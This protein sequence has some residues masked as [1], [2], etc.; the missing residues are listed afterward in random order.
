M[1]PKPTPAER[2]AFDRTTFDELNARRQVISLEISR[3]LIRYVGA[4]NAGFVVVS[5]GLLGTSD[6]SQTFLEASK[7][8]LVIGLIGITLG[9]VA[10]YSMDEFMTAQTKIFKDKWHHILHGGNHYHP[11]PIP[12]PKEKKKLSELFEERRKALDVNPSWTTAF[13]GVSGPGSIS[14]VFT[15]GAMQWA[16]FCAIINMMI[17]IYAIIGW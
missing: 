17:A 1:V 7:W 6:D 16:G 9:G 13:V 4:V 5:A 12:E 8:I 10:L 11:R 14:L 15:A 3:A 2:R